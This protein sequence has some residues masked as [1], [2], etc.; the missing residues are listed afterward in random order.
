MTDAEL[1]KGLYLSKAEAAVIIPKLTPSRRSTLERMIKFGDDWNL[2]AAGFGPRPT[3]ALVD[4][5]R[6][7]RHRKAWR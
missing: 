5:E 3:G 6:S 4:T 7:T 1:A 2:Y